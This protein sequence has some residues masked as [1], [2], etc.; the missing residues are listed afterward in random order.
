MES[1]GKDIEPSNFLLLDGSWKK[2][3]KIL[4]LNPWL[5]HLPALHFAAAEKT[6]YKIRKAQRNDSLSTLESVAWCLENL[7]EVDTAPLYHT[8]EAMID[9]QWR[10]M[11]QE[12]KQRY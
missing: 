2:A 7:D 6:R 9:G 1:I 10:F 12:V 11:S 4:Q 5:S 3:Y 8:F